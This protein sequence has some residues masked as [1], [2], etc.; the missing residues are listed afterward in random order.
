MH[1][2]RKISPSALRPPPFACLLLL[3][4]L[5]LIGCGGRNQRTD[6][7]DGR[8][9]VRVSIL[10]IS[11]QQVE[12]YRMAEQAFEAAHPDVDIIIE[13]FPGVSLK[14]YEIK[15]RLRFS[16]GKA[17]D[18]FHAVQNVVA[19][20]ADM[21]LLAPAPAYIEEM[22]QTNS[23]N[24]MIRR[25]PYFD[26]TCYGITADAAWTILYYNK[27]MFREAGLDPEQPPRT[28][29]E[30]INYAD[31]L[32]VRREDGSPIRAG[33]S[34]RK[35]GFKQGTAEKWLTFLYSAGG[36]PFNEDGT[37]ARFNSPAGRAA[38]DLYRTI[39][40]E[41]NIDSVNLE[42]DQQG[43]GQERVAMFLREVHVIRWLREY[44]PDLDFGVGPVPAREA[45]ITAGGPYLWA[46]SKDSP[47]QEAAWRFVQF[48]M[49]D[50]MYRQYVGIGGVLPVT[51]SVAAAYA[52]DP[53]L[54]VFL[55]QEVAVPDP[56]P[57]IGRAL[58]MLGAYIERFCYG[59]IGANELL[60]RAEHDLNALLIRN[61]KR[62]QGDAE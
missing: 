9:P 18:V 15:L 36:H 44:Y 39:L 35:T 26:G 56:F 43:F 55:D 46:V 21:G 17:P 41:K 62:T 25:A 33:F 50:A 27:Q 28:W 22:V 45:S 31:R 42:G 61:R 10:L 49:Q 12:H 54:N 19:E 59:R 16:S 52:D 1:R 20:Y 51:R 47:H 34:L 24:E 3:V 2:L 4:A 7:T 48:L 11:T 14:D 53:H 13:Q 6:G 32:T 8:I 57:R 38:L 23:L 30:L 60:E 37:A 58:E 5:T 40:F 29:D